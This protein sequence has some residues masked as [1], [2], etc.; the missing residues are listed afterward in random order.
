MFEHNKSIGISYELHNAFLKARA[1][2]SQLSTL[3]YEKLHPQTV[4]KVI[5]WYILSLFIGS[6]QNVL[7]EM[8][9]HSFLCY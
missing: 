9:P 4:K 6:F 7:E 3:Y 5:I 1:L 2:F 8:L